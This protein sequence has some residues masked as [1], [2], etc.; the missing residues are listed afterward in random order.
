MPS[1]RKPA[2]PET[3]STRRSPA[4]R[5]LTRA[6]LAAR[7]ANAAKST[8]PR[9][10]AGKRRSA[11]NAL[12]S[13]GPRT[14]DGKQRSAR[15]STRHGLS[16]QSFLLPSEDPAEFQAHLRDFERNF[17]PVGDAETRLVHHLARTEWKLRRVL[18]LERD[19]F[20]P[21]FDPAA[22][23]TPPLDLTPAPPNDRP[24]PL[25]PVTPLHDLNFTSPLSRSEPSAPNPSTPSIASTPSPAHPSTAS[26]PHIQVAARR[27]RRVLGPRR[28]RDH[29]IVTLG[30]YEAPLQKAYLRALLLLHTHQQR[31]LTPRPDLSPAPGAASS[32]APDSRDA[33][34]PPRAQP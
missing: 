6:E 29:P 22:P 1:T 33:D 30:R 5:P 12:R 20:T 27:L 4:K 26:P 2:A 31:R 10:D 13:T 14:P 32:H 11:A 3:K 19:I 8:G 7:R 28:H 21:R 23:H 9:T 34:L 24:A 25:I 16:S 15:N 18:D 17:R